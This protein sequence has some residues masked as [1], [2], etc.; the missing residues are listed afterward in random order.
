MIDRFFDRSEWSHRK[1]VTRVVLDQAR[2]VEIRE[3]ASHEFE[4][5]TGQTPS[6]LLSASIDTDALDLLCAALTLAEKRPSIRELMSHPFFNVKYPEIPSGDPENNRF[7][8]V[9]VLRDMNAGEAAAKTSRA[10]RTPSM[11]SHDSDPSDTTRS[12]NY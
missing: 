9:R 5:E 8:I 12:S 3:S 1:A 2:T 4:R 6:R 7:R 11:D 10:M